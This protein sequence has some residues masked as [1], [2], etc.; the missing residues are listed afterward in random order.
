MFLGVAESVAGS[1]LCYGVG[2]VRCL[3]NILYTSIGDKAR[4]QHQ[5][6]TEKTD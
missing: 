6:T 5:K 2:I 3:F 1:L 4:S